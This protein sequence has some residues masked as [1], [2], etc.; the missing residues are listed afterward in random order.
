M[1]ATRLWSASILPF[2]LL[3]HQNK[4][5]C[6][7]AVDFQGFGAEEVKIQLLD[8]KRSGPGEVTATWQYQSSSKTPQPLTKG[9]AGKAWV[10][11]RLCWDAE[12]V[13]V[14][15]GATYNIARDQKTQTPLAAKHEP[16]RAG[17]A[18]YINGGTTLKTWAKFP[19]PENV[20][21]VVAKIPGASQP[22]ENVSITP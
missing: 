13:D 22:W 16:Q 20:S 7:Q 9:G 2:V 18:I 3:L 11:Y 4:E 5:P 12:L 21:K 1:R 17:G 10:A 6:C 15:S 14:A 19:V 8:I